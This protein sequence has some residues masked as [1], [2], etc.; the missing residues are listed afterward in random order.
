MVKLRESAGKMFQVEF[1]ESKG[2]DA[3]ELVD[4]KWL[5]EFEIWCKIPVHCGRGS[6]RGRA[7]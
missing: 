6:F 4:E 5:C 3:K 2:K 7:M 1:M